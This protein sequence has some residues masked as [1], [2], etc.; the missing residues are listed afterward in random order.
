MA[1]LG[2]DADTVE[3]VGRQLMAKGQ[4]L[5]ALVRTVDGLINS[6]NAHWW[7]HG[8]RQF[9][10]QWRNVDRK[11]LLQAAQSVEGLGRSAVNNAADQR[12]KSSSAGAAPAGVT[13][14]GGSGKVSDGSGE[15]S[16]AGLVHGF[17]D[18]WN[19]GAGKGK[20]E[21]FDGASGLKYFKALG[22]VLDVL[23]VVEGVIAMRDAAAMHDTGG[24]VGAGVDVGL[25]AG[26][27]VV[28]GAGAVAAGSAVAAAGPLV[29]GVALGKSLVD[30]SIPYSSQSQTELLDYQAQRMFGSDAEHLTPTQ[31]QALVSRY[32]GIGGVAFMISDKMDQS[33]QPIEDAGAAFWRWVGS[34]G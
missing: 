14:A 18:L 28:T 17:T 15:L 33:G 21:W 10:D 27:L 22:P 6:A 11:A 25:G 4:S 8:G 2:M 13:A 31:S 1:R 12:R 5:T 29:F 19:T 32:S 30:Y 26:S 3:A 34:R 20:A 9:V 23:G 16:V 24:M 7:G